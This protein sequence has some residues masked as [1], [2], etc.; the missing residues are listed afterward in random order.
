MEFDLQSFLKAKLAG[1]LKGTKNEW[2]CSG[3]IA[4]SV[5]HDSDLS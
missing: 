4:Y 1:I 3:M 5:K 2:C